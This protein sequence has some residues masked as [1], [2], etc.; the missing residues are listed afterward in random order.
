MRIF[1]SWSGQRSREIAK[2]LRSWLP[3]VINAIE[4]WVSSEDIKPG[5]RWNSEVTTAL[6]ATTIG[7]FCLTPENISSPWVLF[8]AGALAKSVKN[9]KSSVIPFLIP[10]LK[11]TAIAGPLQQFQAVSAGDKASILKMMRQL[12]ATLETV[13]EV[14]LEAGRLQR[15]FERWWPDLEAAVARVVTQPAEQKLG[16]FEDDLKDMVFVPCMTHIVGTTESKLQK[17]L[18]DYPGIWEKYFLA[19]CPAHER[20]SGCFYIDKYQVTNIQYL[21]FVLQTGYTSQST[22]FLAHLPQD[23]RIG[24]VPIQHEIANHPVTYITFE[25]AQKYAEWAGKQ[26]P[27]EIEWE[28]AARGLDAREYPWGNKWEPGRCNS[29]EVAS[30]G[31]VPVGTYELGKSVY[32]CYDMS[33]NAWDWTA[34]WYDAYPGAKKEYYNEQDMGRHNM[35]LRGGSYAWSNFD[36]RCAFRALKE[37]DKALPDISFRCVKHL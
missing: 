25:D 33:G 35:V 29:E 10:G 26:L 31:T 22:E 36:Q 28:L 37:P 6:D 1:I 9:Q 3:D 12:N 4:P 30:N 32:G 24:G 27:T 21:K 7:I 11:I 18:A 5:K 23:V 34:S 16:E 20:T 17:L 15:I 2:A 14:P 8:E 19:E 13:G